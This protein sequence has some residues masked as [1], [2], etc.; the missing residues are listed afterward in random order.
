MDKQHPQQ[1]WQQAVI[2]YAQA[3][4]DYVAQGR[5]HGWDNLEEPQ[6]PATEH[7]LDAWLAALQAANRPGMDEPQRQ[8]FREAWPPAHHPLIPM[9][10]DHG[11]GISH[12]LLL[13]DGSLLA[14]IGM[15]Y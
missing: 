5:A 14:R 4:N 10:E 11:Q 12:V 9:L 8:A 1:Q 13:E 2:A 15:P 6:A 7:L 3:V